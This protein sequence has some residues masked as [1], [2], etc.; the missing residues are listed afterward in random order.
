[1]FEAK[2][3]II[4]EK[5]VKNGIERKCGV[6]AASVLEEEV[7]ND[8]D[9]E[10][11]KEYDE[12]INFTLPVDFK[13]TGYLRKIKLENGGGW[14]IEIPELGTMAYCDCGETPYEAIKKMEDFGKYLI[15][16]TINRHRIEIEELKE[17]IEEE[18]ARKEEE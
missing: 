11:I 15:L 2:S 13:F 8:R 9:K 18:R 3:R 10:R 14:H 16:D 17:K 12:N 1:M 6:W 5:V 7:M 4:A